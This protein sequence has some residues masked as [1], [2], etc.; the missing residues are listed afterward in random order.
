MVFFFFFLM[1]RRPPRSTHC[2]SS[3]ASDV[4]KR[5]VLYTL[6]IFYFQYIDITMIKPANSLWNAQALLQFRQVFFNL[7]YVVNVNMY[8][9]IYNA[10]K[11]YFCKCSIFL[12]ARERL[13]NIGLTFNARSRA[14]RGIGALLAQRSG[15]TKWRCD[16]QDA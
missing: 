9:V 8:S 7:S 11:Y 10:Q 12:P 15:A 5:Q 2:I 4:Y 13:A 14:K 6:Q 16:S 1:I 3:A